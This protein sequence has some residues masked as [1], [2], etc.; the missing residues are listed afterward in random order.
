MQRQQYESKFTEGNPG[1]TYAQ[2][3]SIESVPQDI[4]AEYSIVVAAINENLVL[5]MMA[6]RISRQHFYHPYLG[7]I[8]EG[9]QECYL[10]IGLADEAR[11]RPFLKNKTISP[12]TVIFALSQE[13][14][15]P[16]PNTEDYW[17][18]RIE[19]AH[20]RRQM[21]KAASQ[22]KDKA[23][24]SEIKDEALLLGEASTLI[25][26]LSQK[27]S[28]GDLA[29]RSRV[30][31]VAQRFMN[32]ITV[33]R[34]SPMHRPIPTNMKE[35]NEVLNGGFSKQ[36]LYVI[37]GR[38]GMG[39]SAFALFN[40]AWSAASREIPTAFFSLE[41]SEDAL[42]ARLLAAI[43][44]V[45]AQSIKQGNLSA[46]Q[47]LNI[48]AAMQ[49][50]NG[51]PFYVIDKPMVVREIAGQVKRLKVKTGLSLVVVDY[52]QL[53][54]RGTKD[55]SQETTEN[56][57]TLTRLAKE[58]DVAIVILSQLNRGLESR[59]DKRPTLADFAWSDRIGQD[60]SAV[61]GLYRDYYYTNDIA[62]CEQGEIMVLKNRHGREGAVVNA[63]WD[64]ALTMYSERW[65]DVHG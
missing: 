39:K 64:G 61:I 36:E 9:L 33:K 22:L 18:K 23:W 45:P 24:D 65:G 35:I 28:C 55:I 14:D 51:K 20:F 26:N 44:T 8:W 41:M 49:E 11:V 5:P 42:M 19:T 17:V 2:E 40:V 4:Q 21:I 56:V 62:T 25:D 7:E 10:Q 3:S 50:L 48:Q 37:G 53:L 46:Q 16:T 1:D 57:A 6:S 60:A 13:M 32:N 43:A 38:P 30:D 52:I 59:G 12:E 54:N 29:A 27:V 58:A 47:E 31:V 34:N 63:R 15:E